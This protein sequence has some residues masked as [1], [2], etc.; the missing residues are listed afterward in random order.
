MHGPEEVEVIGHDAYGILFLIEKCKAVPKIFHSVL[1]LVF[2]KNPVFTD[3]LGEKIISHPFREGLI[4]SLS[5]RHDADAVRILFQVSNCRI[6]SKAKYRTGTVRPNL[7]SE[8]DQV[9]RILFSSVTEM[10]SN[11]ALRDQKYD[12]AYKK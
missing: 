11:E 3:S 9:I 5:S 4:I 8:Y 2:H 6:Q 7:S 10:R 12:Q 1:R